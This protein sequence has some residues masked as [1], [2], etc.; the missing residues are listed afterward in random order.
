MKIQYIKGYFCLRYKILSFW[1]TEKPEPE[2]SKN[3]W[4]IR[5]EPAEI[6]TFV[7]YF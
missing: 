1:N 6:R 7:L 2:D 3:A 4:E 5:L